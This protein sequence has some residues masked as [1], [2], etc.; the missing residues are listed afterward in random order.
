[1]FPLS[2]WQAIWLGVAAFSLITS[3]AVWRARHA[4]TDAVPVRITEAAPVGAPV[5][6]TARASAPRSQPLYVHVSGQV[7]R[8]GLYRFQPGARVMDAVTGA[9]G[10]TEYANLDALNLATPLHDGQK[11]IVPRLGESPPQAHLTYLL[12][13]PP[14]PTVTL[15]RPDPAPTRAAPDAYVMPPPSEAAFAAASGFSS[16]GWSGPAPAGPS[17]T[18]KLRNPGEGV[19]SLN[20][21]SFTELQRLPGVGPSTAQ[22]IMDYRRAHGGFRTVDELMEVKGIG[23][24]KLARMAPFV[25]L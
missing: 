22:K 6:V 7:A 3:S 15:V 14:P 12:D 25:R 10:A 16:G 2:R 23:E 11:L 4:A 1:M 5:R 13:S 21:A 19:V 9:G 8:P 18:G 20:T 24:K 17:S